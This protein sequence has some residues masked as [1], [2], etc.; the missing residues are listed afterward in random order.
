MQAIRRSRSLLVGYAKNDFLKHILQC[1]PAYS[2]LPHFL[3]NSLP[4]LEKV[5]ISED[6]T[7]LKMGTEDQNIPVNTRR[8]RVGVIGMPNVGKSTLVNAM[9]NKQ[10]MAT[11]TRID[12]TVKNSLG[13][14]TDGD[15]QIEFQDSPGIFNKSKSKRFHG[16]IKG[17]DFPSSCFAESDLCMVVVDLSMKRTTNGFLDPEVLVELI[18]HQHIPSILVINKIDKVKKRSRIYPLIPQLTGGF[19]NGVDCRPQSNKIQA[20]PIELPPVKAE[21]IQA[22]DRVEELASTKDF[23]FLYRNEEK[24]LRQMRSCRGW[25]YFKDVFVISALR[26]WETD[27]LR[28]YL[29]REAKNGNWNYPYDSVTTESSYDII[30]DIVRSALLDNLPYE[31]PY[32]TEVVISEWRRKDSGLL[33]LQF[34]L[35]CQKYAHARLMNQN[36][37]T[38]LYSA[39]TRIETLLNCEI[40]L[41]LVPY[42]K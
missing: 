27:R 6:G 21:V 18:K 19:V 42:L 22:I 3:L 39:K 12:T 5:D 40:E 23:Q 1:Q 26:G 38:I 28:N 10:V 20:K 33:D 37:T 11:S 35:V 13:I 2:T 41:V 15:V 7:K 34:D 4:Q 36:M 32:Q 17:K 8:L 31:I 29:N 24:M 25:P 16:K 9:I 14:L 30:K